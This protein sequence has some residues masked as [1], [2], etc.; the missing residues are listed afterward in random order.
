M[1]HLDKTAF[2]STHPNLEQSNNYFSDLCW[3]YVEITSCMM[4]SDRGDGAIHARMLMW[5]YVC[6]Y[7]LARE[8]KPLFDR[9]RDFNATRSPHRIGAVL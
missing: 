8:N 7:L 2:S 5:I 3:L 6:M 9:R 4:I 1:I